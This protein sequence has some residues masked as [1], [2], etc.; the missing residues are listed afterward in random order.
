MFDR[1]GNAVDAASLRPSPSP[2]C[3]STE[4]PRW[5]TPSGS[6][7][8]R[9][10]PRSGINAAG[11]SAASVDLDAYR[12]RF[13]TR[14][15]CAA[16]PRRS[17]CRCGLGLGRD[18]SHS[19]ERWARRSPGA[20]ASM[21]ACSRARGLPRV[22]V[23]RRITAA[24]RDIFGAAA[25]VE[26]QRSLGPSITRPP[27][28]RSRSHALAD[29]LEHVA[30]DGGQFYTGDVA[31]DLP[32]APPPWQSLTANDL[33]RASRRVGQAAAYPLSWRRSRQLYAG[34]RASPRSRSSACSQ[35][36]DVGMLSDADL[37]PCR[38]RG[39]QARVPGP[40]PLPHRPSV[41]DVPVQ[42]C[43]DPERLTERRGR[44]RDARRAPRPHRAGGDTIA[45]VSADARGNAVCVTEPLSRVR[46]GVVAA[47][48]RD[49]QNRGAFSRSIPGIQPPGA[50][51]A[52]GTT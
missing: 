8:M 29:T 43:L 6:F 30:A 21:R 5:R 10:R 18:P 52:D 14:C 13:G 23:Q 44:S 42:R 20:P 34:R 25:P 28:G 46:R 49:L 22:A 9:R 17:R 41:V 7:T 1:G 4:R 35:G 33:A 45:I 27:R 12:S 47:T 32:P 40:R 11:R 19:V 38:G 36:F 3:T 50:A 51:Q 16:A 31:G 24:A 26:V 2:S 39:D 48:G 15:R 37:H